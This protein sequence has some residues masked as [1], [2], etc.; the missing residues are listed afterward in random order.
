MIMLYVYDRP[1]NSSITIIPW[2]RF[3][4]IIIVVFFFFFFQL[5]EGT[6]PTIKRKRERKTIVS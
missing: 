3:S 6:R 5:F 4:I 2:F 1:K